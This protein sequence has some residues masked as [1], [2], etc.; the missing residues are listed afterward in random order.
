M[1]DSLTTNRGITIPNS[2]DFVHEGPQEITR[3]AES[4]DTENTGQVDYLLPGVVSESDWS[5]TATISSSTAALS[6]EANTGGLAWIDQATV[7]LM[8]TSTPTGSAITSIAV[9]TKPSSGKYMTVGIELT[10]TTWSKSVTVSTV[11]GVEHNTQAEAEAASPAVTANKIRVRDVCIKNTAGVY[12]IVSQIDR[13]GYATAN[14]PSF[15]LQQVA[16]SGLTNTSFAL[17][18]HPSTVNV[19][20][21]TPRVVLIAARAIVDLTSGTG[22]VTCAL[23]MDET[24]IYNASGEANEFLEGASESRSATVSF[25][26]NT[27]PHTGGQGFVAQTKLGENW[28]EA[29]GSSTRMFAAPIAV[30]VIASGW[31]V[32]ALLYKASEGVTYQVVDQ[33]LSVY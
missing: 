4:I 21:A 26:W 33:T 22:T 18:T 30:Y 32:F 8:R 15:S 29:S 1:A 10:P 27:E 19:Y 25:M 5:F 14:R 13:R 24:S 17:P 12:S 11:S 3:V 23:R 16:S 31:H 28:A 2:N 20:L 7:G 9:G 6:S